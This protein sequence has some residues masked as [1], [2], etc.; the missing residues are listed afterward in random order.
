MRGEI[1]VVGEDSP[2]IGQGLLD[3]TARADFATV[4]TRPLKK[5]LDVIGRT[6]S[7]RRRR[8]LPR[9]TPA[10]A[11]AAPAEEGTNHG[12]RSRRGGAASS[13]LLLLVVTLLLEK[14]VL[15]L[16]KQLL[17]KQLLLKQLLLKQLLGI[18][19]RCTAP[20]HTHSR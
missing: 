5:D 13:S 17:L 11:P 1:V 10:P 2:D 15:V 3:D 19:L 16:L 12:H 8:R 4:H 9:Q 18:L 6:H 7:S 20:C 14:P